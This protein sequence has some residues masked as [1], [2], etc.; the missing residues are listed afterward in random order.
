ML[1][2]IVLA[3]SAAVVS[4]S[5][6]VWLL[7]VAPRLSTRVA[8]EMGSARAVALKQ[9]ADCLEGSNKAYGDRWAQECRAQWERETRQCRVDAMCVHDTYSIGSE[10]CI[11]RKYAADVKL[12]VSAVEARCSAAF[13][14][15][16]DCI[17][18]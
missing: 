18:E 7:Y 5:L 11:P 1:I 16:G 13:P 12:D 3:F 9:Y 15:S 8:D 2:K 14:P 17:L 10:T 6:S 4:V